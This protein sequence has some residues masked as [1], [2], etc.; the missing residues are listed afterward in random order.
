MRHSEQADLSEELM[1]R[2]IRWPSFL[3]IFSGAI[4]AFLFL[5]FL[6]SRLGWSA[7]ADAYPEIS[8]A[9]GK[10]WWFQYA[11][12]NIVD[13]R[14]CVFFTTNQK[15]LSLSTLFAFRLG[16][17]PIFIPWSDISIENSN[18][19]FLPESRIRTK[20]LP[21]LPIAISSQLA[22]EIEASRPKSTQK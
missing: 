21:T 19:F 4:A 20:R 6:V 22:Q 2:T 1:H 10:S 17:S 15:G 7:V 12:I 11:K 8:D 16:H 14:S 3:L 9:S 5:T 18:S 13:Y